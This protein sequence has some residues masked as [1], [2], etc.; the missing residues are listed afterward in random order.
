LTSN[1]DVREY[2]LPNEGL[3]PRDNISPFNMDEE[4]S[5]DDSPMRANNEERQM[6]S[7]AAGANVKQDNAAMMAA[8]QSS[9]E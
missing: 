9:P 6:M 5:R 3:D 8:A 7:N 1:P 2:S 4:P